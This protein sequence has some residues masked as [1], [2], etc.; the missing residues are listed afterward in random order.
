LSV[1]IPAM[2]FY[3]GNDLFSINIVLVVSNVVF[4]FVVKHNYVVYKRV[5]GWQ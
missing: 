5:K 3:A 1:L 4:I 2:G